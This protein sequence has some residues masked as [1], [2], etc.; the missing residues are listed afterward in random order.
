MRFQKTQP[1][2]IIVMELEKKWREEH[3]IFVDKKY[4]S[5]DSV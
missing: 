4:I 2:P 1:R 5:I 3:N